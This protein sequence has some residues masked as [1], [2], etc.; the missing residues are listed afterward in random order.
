M[1]MSNQK[2]KRRTY[3]DEF[4]NQLIKRTLDTFNIKS[5]LGM[6]GCPYDNVVEEGNFKTIKTEF[7]NGIYFDFLEEL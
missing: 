2:R 1:T 4:K 7:I 5:S 3:T 6:K